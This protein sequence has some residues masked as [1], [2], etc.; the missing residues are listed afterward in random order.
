MLESLT[1]RPPSLRLFAGHRTLNDAAR[2]ILEQPDIPVRVVDSADDICLP[3]ESWNAEKGLCLKEPDKAVEIGEARQKMD[4]ALLAAL[5]LCAGDTLQAEALFRLLGSRVRG[6]MIVE[7]ICT[8]CPEA[9]ACSAHYESSLSGA[10][11][12]LKEK[13]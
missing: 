13:S 6:G 3:C 8:A 2:R 4:Q 11:E 5:G 9:A 7:K 12:Q 1:A 10:L